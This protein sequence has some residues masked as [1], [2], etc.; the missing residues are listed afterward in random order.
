MQAVPQT[1]PYFGQFPGLIR[2]KEHG[3]AGAGKVRFQAEKRFRGGRNVPDLRNPLGD[4][5]IEG[6]VK[7]VTDLPDIP[8]FDCIEKGGG[9]AFVLNPAFIQPPVGIRRTDRD[10]RENQE[11]MKPRFRRLR[12]VNPLNLLATPPA[13]AQSTD[14]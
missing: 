10:I 7:V 1:I 4:H 9:A 12:Y 3:G 11:D 5:G 13:T 2:Q 14:Q 8:S 6:I